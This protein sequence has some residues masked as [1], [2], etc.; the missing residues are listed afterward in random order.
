MDRFSGQRVLGVGLGI[1]LAAAALAITLGTARAASSGG[2]LDRGFGKNG[3]VV[4]RFRNLAWPSA[5]AVG[6]AGRIVAAGTLEGPTGSDGVAFTRYSRRG[7]LDRRVQ[8][9]MREDAVYEP[10]ATAVAIQENGKIVVGSADTPG[11]RF[12]LA[13]YTTR[14]TLDSSFGPGGVVETDIGS[15]SG[16]TAVAIQPDGNIV[17]AGYG[18]RGPRSTFALARY[19]PN[20]TL[21]ASFGTGGTVTTEIGSSSAA[22]AVAL[23]PNGKIVVVGTTQRR[24]KT[25]WALARYTRDGKL[26]PTFSTDGKVVAPVRCHDLRSLIVSVSVAV[27]SNGKVVVTGRSTRHGLVLARY[28]TRGTLDGTFGTGGT[29]RAD[30]GPE[31]AAGLAIEPD[32]KIVVLGT[33]TNASHYEW[34]LIRYTTRGTLD[35]SFGPGGKVRTLMGAPNEAF[36]MAIQQGGKIVVAGDSGSG[37][38]VSRYLP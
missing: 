29:V 3:T 13:R 19:T 24:G 21:D 25:Y 12:T 37:F 14:G 10:A 38:A 1:A 18:Y 9:D 23:A 5:V 4:T 31:S 30:I 33:T 6:P 36:A 20:G 16:V 15:V 28:T 7:Q 2:A 8:W 11:E 35:T 26:D 27:Q 32:G 22:T 34:G 17:A